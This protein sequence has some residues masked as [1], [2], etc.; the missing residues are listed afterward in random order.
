MPVEL[1][2]TVVLVT[3]GTGLVGYAIRHI[4]ET[5][6]VGSRFGRREDEAWVFIGSKD[7][8]LRFVSRC[9]LFGIIPTSLALL[10]Q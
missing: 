2:K 9:S 5:E 7:A 3:G 1:P 4:I 6:A 8:D 10:P